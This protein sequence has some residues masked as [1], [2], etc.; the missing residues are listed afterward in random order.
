MYYYLNLEGQEKGIMWGN[1]SFLFFRD[2]FNLIVLKLRK[3]SLMDFK[4]IN[5]YLEDLEVILK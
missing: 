4:E 2:L 3:D 5:L 1:L